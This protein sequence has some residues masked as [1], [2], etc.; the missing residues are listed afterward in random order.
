MLISNENSKN[1]YNSS[2]SCSKS[3]STKTN[4]N[5]ENK[6]EDIIIKNNFDCIDYSCLAMLDETP[7]LFD[8]ITADDSDS[9]SLNFIAP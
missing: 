5:D 7:S 4:D 8:I 6:N 2:K 9:G 1:I 3:P